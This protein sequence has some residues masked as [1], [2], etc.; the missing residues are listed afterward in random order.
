MSLCF[1]RKIIRFLCFRWMQKL[2]NLWRHLKHE[3][4]SEVTISIVCFR[5]P[6]SIWMKF[7]HI[8]VQ[9]MKNISNSFLPLLL[10]LKTSFRPFYDF[11]TMAVECNLIIFGWWCLKFLI[12]LVHTV[13]KVK[14]LQ[15]HPKHFINCGK[16]INWIESGTTTQPSQPCK[17]FPKNIPHVYI[18]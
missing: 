2:Q 12:V 7:G 8:F 14:I 1:V 3:C 11:D 15:V 16:S 17:C 9:L 18:H 13:K 5:V 6:G 4:F 10:R